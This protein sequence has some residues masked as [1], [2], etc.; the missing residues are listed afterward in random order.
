MKLG[1]L[2]GVLNCC[3]K[4]V[5]FLED[6][7]LGKDLMSCHSMDIPKDYYESIILNVFPCDDFLYLILEPKYHENRI[8]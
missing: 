5:E 2:I 7:P 1:E 3:V 6:D 4:L 8:G